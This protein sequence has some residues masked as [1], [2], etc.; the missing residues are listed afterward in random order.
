MLTKW[1]LNRDNGPMRL[2]VPIFVLIACVLF[3]ATIFE[4]GWSSAAFA[5]D[6]RAEATPPSDAPRRVIVIVNRNRTVYGWL[7]HIDDDVIVVRDRDT[8]EVESFPLSRINELVYL[9]DPKPNQ[10]GIVVMRSGQLR[11]G[12]VLEDAWEYVLLEIEGIRAKLKR[13]TVMYTVLEPSFEQR[14]KAFKEALTPEM[15]DQYLSLCK[16]LIS[17]RRYEL[18]RDELDLLSKYHAS[19]EITYLRRLVNAQLA[20]IEQQHAEAGDEETS[21]D[22]GTQS[23]DDSEDPAASNLPAELLTH[24][25]VNVIRVYEIDFDRPPKVDVA[26][27]VIR[28]LIAAYSDR[29][30]IPSS[31]AGRNEL[32]RADPLEIVRLMFTLRA[33]EFYPR[34]EVNSEPYSLN[35]FRQRVHNA[36]LINRCATSRCHG[37]PESGRFF[38]HRRGYKDSRVRYTNFLILERLKLDPEWPLLNYEDPELSLIIQYAMPREEARKPHP[39]V[40]GWTPVFRPGVDRLKSRAI[41]WIR[42]MLKPRPEYPV[43]FEP[44]RLTPL[45]AEMGDGSDES[46]PAD[47]DRAPR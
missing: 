8:D 32:F 5:T 38:L 9:V 23:E 31:L 3:G 18:A 14:Y 30:E 1:M 15:H 21:D 44:P 13:D 6:D 36:W 41:E 43:Q 27:D 35:L 40:K 19:N 37:G 10:Q 46:P 42:S 2:L 24:A 28:D 17:E 4:A 29:K 22:D 7:E 25:D 20:L 34:V 16:W 39:D 26:P 11:E 47:D 12:V 33:R 45:G